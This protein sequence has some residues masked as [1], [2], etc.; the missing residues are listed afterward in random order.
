MG[1]K[2]FLIVLSSGKD[3]SWLLF[4]QVYSF[5]FWTCKILEVQLF[6]IPPSVPKLCSSQESPGG[7]AHSSPGRMASVEG[8]CRTSAFFSGS[9]GQAFV[10]QILVG[11]DTLRARLVGQF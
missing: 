8:I 5:S 11:Q 7:R 10:G 3:P 6:L 4:W 2:D 9:L 1:I